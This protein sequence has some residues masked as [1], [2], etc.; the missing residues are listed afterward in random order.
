MNN[1]TLFTG[2]SS[3][4]GYEMAVLL[5]AQQHNLILVARNEAKLRE[6]SQELSVKYQVAVEYKALD[7][8]EAGAAQALYT[9]VQQSQWQVTALVNNAGTGV[10]GDFVATGLDA[11][12]RMIQLNVSTV[13]ALSKL[14]AQD[15]VARKSG[16]ILNVASLLSF[17]PFPYY[18]VYSATKA[19]VLAFT[20]TISAEL[21]GTG[22]VVTALCPGPTDTA[23]NTSDM[24]NTNAYGANKPV[25]PAVVAKA[26]VALLLKGK[27]KKIV[28]FQNWFLSNLPRVTPDVL[29]MKIKKQLASQKG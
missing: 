13:V 27:G 29:M 25:S 28:G 9:Y 4:I 24:L 26:G 14:F 23:F 22:V 10:Y 3:G 8:S 7:L 11:D 5:A 21:E 12:L 1:Y 15:M 16:R 2:A 6:M 17:L 18:S 20:E 19:F